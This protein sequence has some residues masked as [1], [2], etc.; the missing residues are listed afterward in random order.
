MIRRLFKVVIP[1]RAQ[2]SAGVG[3]HD[4]SLQS[5]LHTANALSRSSDGDV[6]SAR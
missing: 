6:G 2:V 4:R 5:Q 1:L 3:V